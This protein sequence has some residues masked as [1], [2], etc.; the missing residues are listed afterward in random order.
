[1][2]RHCF[3]FA[4]VMLLASS[5]F[6]QYT[7]TSVDYPGAAVTRFVGLNDHSD[8]VGHYIMPGGVRHAMLFSNGQFT[9]LDPDGILGTHT[10]AANQ[11]SNRG[12]ISGWYA[13]AAGRH[14]YVIHQGVVNTIDYP[15]TSY[16]QVN[17]V[18]DNGTVIGHYKGGDGH[19]HGF[20]LQD[21]NFTPIDFPG[22][23][24]TYPY[25]MNAR[26]DI[27]GEWT[28][29]S[30]TVGHGFLL[31]KDGQWTGFDAPGAPANSTLAIG[32]N[33]HEQVL[34]EYFETNGTPRI[35]IV[36]GR[37]LDSPDAFSF[38]EMPWQA[39]SPETSNNSGVFVG[40]YSDA[41]GTHGFV[42]IPQP[43]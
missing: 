18:T 22:G 14:G 13:D 19:M 6:A 27:A 32:V 17:G 15:G 4:V 36:S 31:T 30:G 11:I 40:F 24:D 29:V 5:C 34:G 25:Y 38:I 16:T 8:I 7:F 33:D 1:M 28:S 43:K 20:V 12:D 9:P 41:A 39:S 42:A 2:N 21:G 3:I 23:V 35:F 26:G 10:S 37:R